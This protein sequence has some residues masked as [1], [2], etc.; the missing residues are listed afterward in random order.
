MPG[1]LMTR[2]SG[3]SVCLY[4]F[5][6]NEHNTV[7]VAD[8]VFEMLLYTQFIGESDKDDDLKQ[9]AAESKSVFV[10]NEGWLNIPKIMDHFITEKTGF[11]MASQNDFWRKKE[12]NVS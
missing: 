10:D 3:S 8:R 1:I 11:I 5:I 9:L 12:G 7:A 4:G 6:R 2:N